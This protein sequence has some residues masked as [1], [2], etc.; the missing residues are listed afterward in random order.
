MKFSDP[1]CVAQGYVDQMARCIRQ[2][3]QDMSTRASYHLQQL[4]Q[5]FVCLN[6]VKARVAPTDWRGLFGQPDSHGNTNRA[7]ALPKTA[8]SEATVSLCEFVYYQVGFMWSS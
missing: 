6:S 8:Y 1:D 7:V 3:G 4:L 2:T 5:E